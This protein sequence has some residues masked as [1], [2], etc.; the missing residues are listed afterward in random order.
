[1]TSLSQA[2]TLGGVGS[3]LV[4][5]SIVP[6]VGTV[7]AIAGFILILVAIKQIADT[8][9]KKA[10]FND[11]LIATI[12]AIAGVA[13]GFLVLL[14]TFFATL[15]G[16]FPGGFP[17]T[18]APGTPLVSFSGGNIFG[19]VG[20]LLAGLAV[21]WISLI[22]SAIFL[23]RSYGKIADYLNVG[24]F[25]TAAL[26]YLIGAALTIVLVGFLILFVAEVLQIVAFFSMPDQ[27][28]MQPAMTATT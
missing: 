6:A 19:I 11:M 9:Q 28:P 22:V 1:M 14:S 2:K 17:T 12:L 23:R 26:L 16:L 24:M 21:I 20:G 4:I 3:I 18:F 15:S 25:R 27:P 5:L 8:S 7:L 10:I 13:V